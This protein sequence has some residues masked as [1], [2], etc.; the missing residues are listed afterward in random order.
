MRSQRML[1]SPANTRASMEARREVLRNPPP[2]TPPRSNHSENGRMAEIKL[3]IA[4]DE[5]WCY[6]CTSPMKTLSRDMKKTIQQFLQLRR[7]TYP[8]VSTE[9]CVNAKNLSLLHKQKCRH[10]H[11]T[12]ISLV[13]HNQ[14]GAS[15]VLRGCAENFG[16]VDEKYLEK[17]GDNSCTR[18]IFFTYLLSKIQLYNHLPTSRLRTAME[19]SFLI[20]YNPSSS[21][22]S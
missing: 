3:I 16:A 8:E 12:T 13:D 20:S 11:C 6:H 7:A 1:T 10:R 18:Y 9:E 17:Q 19:M 15:F 21:S 5:S 14:G 4:A 22:R 2:P